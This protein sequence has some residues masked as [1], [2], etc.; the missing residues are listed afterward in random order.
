MKAGAARTT[1][2]CLST[3]A[4]PEQADGAFVTELRDLKERT[5]LSL[6]ALAARTPYSK[7]A[8]HRYL[9]GSQRPPR[10]AVEALAG[11]VGVDPAP[12]LAL[13]EAADR[14]PVADA[15]AYDGRAAWP[16]RPRRL[17]LSALTL[18]VLVASA[19]VTLI[20]AGRSGAPSGQLTAALPRCKRE[21]CQGQL[22]D[23]SACDRDAQIKSTVHGATYAV[24]LEYSPSCGTAW[25]EVQAQPSDARVISVR[26][27][28]NVLSASYPGGGSGGR[29][30][31][32]LAVTSPEGV[33]ACAVVDGTVACTGLDADPPGVR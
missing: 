31:P 16:V 5:G 30:S 6:A 20:A 29:M 8:W 14:P 1:R 12:V 7:S 17:S 32:M 4:P 24:R 3:A 18:I 23:V 21:S 13:R 33:E 28:R 26:S 2:P 27:G 11:L 15:P 22:P 19:A 25:A 10:S 9:N